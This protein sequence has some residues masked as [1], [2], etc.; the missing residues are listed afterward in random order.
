MLVMIIY[1]DI[2]N[3]YADWRRKSSF[4]CRGH[5]VIKC[6]QFALQDRVVGQLPRITGIVITYDTVSIS[7]TFF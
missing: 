7:P 5:Y 6:P 4:L 2:Y 3:K 1:K